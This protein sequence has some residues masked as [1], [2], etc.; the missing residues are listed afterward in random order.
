MI[1]R[2]LPQLAKANTCFNV[3]T[4]EGAGNGPKKKAVF[5]GV[6][7]VPVFLGDYSEQL[8]PQS[9]DV[10]FSISVIEHVPTKD[11]DN[12]LKDGLRILKP[13]GLWVHAID[14][15]LEDTLPQAERACSRDI[16]IGSNTRN[17]TPSAK[18][19]TV[20]RGSAATWPPIR[21]T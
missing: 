13:G 16:A 4:F 20:P 14:M 8:A 15:Y 5:K 7:N 17:W 10:V 2:V 6:T 3:D 11:L 9:F 18:S 1:L 21:T 19:M 12:F